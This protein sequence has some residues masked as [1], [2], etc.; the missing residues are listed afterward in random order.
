M[1]TMATIVG[2]AAPVGDLALDVGSC[3]APVGWALGA[4]LA[5]S[6]A[7][8]VVMR[9]QAAHRVAVAAVSTM[10]TEEAG[11]RLGAAARGWAWGRLP[12][13]REPSGTVPADTLAPGGLALRWLSVA[14]TGRLAVAAVAAGGIGSRCAW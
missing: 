11:A 13:G 9:L 2:I 7:V 8:I 1:N 4:L 5:A 12:V 6:A 10:T 14:Q 3:L